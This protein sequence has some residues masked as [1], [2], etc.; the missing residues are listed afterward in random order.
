MTYDAIN[1]GEIV[2]DSCG[3]RGSLG[4]FHFDGCDVAGGREVMGDDNHRDG[5]GKVACRNY[6]LRFPRCHPADPAKCSACSMGIAHVAIFGDRARDPNRVLFLEVRVLI[7][8]ECFVACRTREVEVAERIFGQV[9]RA[10]CQAYADGFSSGVAEEAQH[11]PPPRRSI[12]A[13]L[14]ARL[15]LS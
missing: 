15:G 9:Q 11:T 12:W 3:A 4:A 2:C 5:L 7:P 13:R 8:G 6:P 10:L 1:E 14:R